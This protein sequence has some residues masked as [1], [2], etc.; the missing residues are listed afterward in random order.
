MTVTFRN[1]YG[2]LQRMELSEYMKLTERPE[3]LEQQTKRY[4]VK[5]SGER[6]ELPDEDLDF[7]QCNDESK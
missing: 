2:L 6:I 5:R 4:I 3:L 7:H 1:K